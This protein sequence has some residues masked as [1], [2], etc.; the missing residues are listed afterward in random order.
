MEKDLLQSI[1]SAQNGDK[2]EMAKLVE[3]NQGLIWNIAKRFLGRGY[4]K[5]DI[6]Q[7]GCMGFIK[8]IR[9]FDASYNV[10]LST[11]AVPYIMGEI[12]K[13]LRDDGPIKVSRSLK[14]LNIKIIELQREYQK[15][16][17]EISV[18]ELS[19]ILRMPKEEII[20]AMES[21]QQTESIEYTNYTNQKSDKSLS[22]LETLSTNKDEAT[23][24]V[25]KVTIQKIIQN[26]KKR[27]KEIILLRF[28]KDKTQ[29]EV[30]K[31]LGISQ[32]QVSRIEKKVLTN[33]KKELV[34]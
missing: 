13:F 23:A 1:I 2:D 4:D 3:E 34:S 5:E 33:I 7:I 14:E 32:V 17:K 8:S 27:E 30:A 21:A 11:Y 24:I 25:N 12:K 20:L 29:T 26:L 6:Y 31:I 19:K 18:I 15:Q 28:Y 9:R 22:L 16:G 10:K